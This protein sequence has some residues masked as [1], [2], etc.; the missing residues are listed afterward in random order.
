MVLV[1]SIV[2]LR[3][4]FSGF[5]ASLVLWMRRPLYG[6]VYIL[7][8]KMGYSLGHL[9]IYRTTYAVACK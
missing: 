8:A 3:E 5:E 6:F 9:F 1:V 4:S 7:K 2:I